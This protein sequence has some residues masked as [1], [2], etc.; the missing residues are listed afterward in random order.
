MPA[1]IKA[2]TAIEEAEGIDKKCCACRQR[3]KLLRRVTYSKNYMEETVR[4]LTWN[5]I[6]A[7]LNPQC[8]LYVSRELENWIPYYNGS[9]TTAGHKKQTRH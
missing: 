1:K 5:T 4:V 3:G 8:F 7:C 6:V 9:D 2:M